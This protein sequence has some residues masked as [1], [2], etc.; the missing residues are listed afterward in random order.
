MTILS[1][2][3]YVYHVRIWCLLRGEEGVRSPETRVTGSCELPGGSGEPNKQVLLANEPP[4]QPQEA[5]RWERVQSPRLCPQYGKKTL[6]IIT[7][8]YEGYKT[9]WVY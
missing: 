5:W 7:K 1:E 8:G 6:R 3:S 2:C 9:F 4:L